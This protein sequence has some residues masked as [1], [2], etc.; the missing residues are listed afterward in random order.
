MAINF[1]L[2]YKTREEALHNIKEAV[3]LYLEPVETDVPMFLF[4][5]ITRIVKDDKKSFTK[6]LDFQ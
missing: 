5:L 4:R 1:A 2:N 3:E 6:C